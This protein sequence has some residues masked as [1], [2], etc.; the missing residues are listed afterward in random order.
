VRAA[1]C[2]AFGEPLVIEEL[3]LTPPETGEVRVEIAACAICH[4]D[5]AF[6]DGDWGGP[7]PAVYGHEAAGVV[8]EVGSGVTAVDPGDSVVVTLLRSCGRCFFCSRGEWHLCEGTFA[9]DRDA[10]LRTDAGET[11]VPAMRTGAFAEEVVVHESQ[12]AVAPSTLS[13]E[14]A[15]LLGCGVL[16]GVGAVLNQIAVEPGSSVV[17]I[18]TGGVGLNVV[19]GSVLAG[20]TQIV[21]VDISA[22]KRAAAEAFGATHVV[23]PAADEPALAV[24]ALTD[25]RG[26]DYAFVTAAR[27][28][29]IERSLACVRRGGT[30]VVL[31][32]PATGER[33]SVVAVDLVHDDVRIVGSKIGSGS[34]S[35]ADAIL[36]LAGLYE[37]G[38]LKLDELITGRYPLE[39]INDAIAAA[40]H[41]DAVRN[42]VL[43]GVR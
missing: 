2:R 17:V 39:R 29:P 30:V 36:R 14:A 26:A 41:G 20:A 27:G 40:R 43:P 11:V 33:F 22:A 3:T 5:I 12:V 24:R 42:L 1:V 31:G 37:Q 13:P 23:D 9:A 38:R 6:A 34:P 15:A 19:Q 8:R 28:D 35:L 4:S 21:A 25:G 32:M 18:G 10:R 16:T 7:L